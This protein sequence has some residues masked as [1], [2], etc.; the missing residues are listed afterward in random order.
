MILL[1]F[2][3]FGTLNIING[4]SLP[5]E[6]GM[7]VGGYKSDDTDSLQNDMTAILAGIKNVAVTNMITTLQVGI[8]SGDNSCLSF[9]TNFDFGLSIESG[10]ESDSALSSISDFLVLLESKLTELGAVQTGWNSHLMKFQL[11]T[12]ILFQVVRDCV[13]LIWRN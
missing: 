10:V 2:T 12:K 9:A 7:I 6:M 13:M 3:A 5:Q 1:G 8:N 4:E 11:N